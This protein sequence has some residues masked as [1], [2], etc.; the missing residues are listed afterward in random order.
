MAKQLRR[1]SHRMSV[2]LAALG[3]N[4]ANI[5]N[6]ANVASG[7]DTDATVGGRRKRVSKVVIGQPEGFKHIGTAGGGGGGNAGGEGEAGAPEV[8]ELWSVEAWR[9]EIERTLSVSAA[10]CS[11]F[12]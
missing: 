3:I 12:R 11:V 1:K 10:F 5:G 8:P 7:T 9:A 4:I 6:F 2:P